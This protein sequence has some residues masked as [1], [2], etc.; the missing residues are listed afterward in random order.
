MA[1]KVYF[2]L[3]LSLLAT[4]VC[5]SHIALAGV[6]IGSRSDEVKA[7]QEILK[8]DLSIYPEGY[9]TGYYGPLT[10]NAVKKLQKRC[11][12]PETG[13]LDDATEKCIYPIEYKVTV[14]SPNGGEVLDR[15][16]I[17]TIKW[18]VTTPPGIAEV[19]PFW[20]EAS[21]D[22]FR[23]EYYKCGESSDQKCPGVVKSVFV[24]HIATVNLLDKSYSWRI[25]SDI[26]N[27]KD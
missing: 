12:L 10:V 22:L 15:N 19:P 20:P 21:I 24:R 4:I 1:K 16:T 7:I 25:S 17:Q 26:P 8:E 2:L 18:E 23:K 13:E 14:V 5:F 3:F 9:V 27:S 11:G 6:A